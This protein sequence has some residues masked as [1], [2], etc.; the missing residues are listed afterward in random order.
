MSAAVA[1][2][3]QALGLLAAADPVPMRC[4]VGT[5]RAVLSSF[6]LQQD[7]RSPSAADAYRMVRPD[8]VWLVGHDAASR[9][10]DLPK[11]SLQFRPAPEYTTIEVLFPEAAFGVVTFT[12]LTVHLSENASLVLIGAVEDTA[13]SKAAD[14]DRVMARG[15]FEGVDTRRKAVDLA[16][17]LINRL[18]R[19]VRLEPAD[20]RTVWD[21][22]LAVGAKKRR[23]A[24]TWMSEVYRN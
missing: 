19:K 2:Q 18:P 13:L 17:C 7:H 15:F 14:A 9:R 23:A 4:E 11:T 16:N 12:K 5:C 22:V 6:C 3:P 20:R 8:T 1:G 10:I 21:Q 24:T